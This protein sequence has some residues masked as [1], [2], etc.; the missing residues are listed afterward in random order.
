MFHAI[1]TYHFYPQH[2]QEAS[3][4]W[5]TQVARII[6]KQPGFIRV[7]FYTNA[8]G[9]AVAI[10]SWEAKEYAD[11]FMKTGVFANL[12]KDLEHMMS[13]VP[14]GGPYALEYFEEA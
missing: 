1:M 3:A 2:L 6:A 10:G 4:L 11:D 14:R 5:H 7:Q 12:L 8:D 9:T 13:E